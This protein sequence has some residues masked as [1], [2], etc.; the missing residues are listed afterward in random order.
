MTFQGMVMHRESWPIVMCPVCK[1]QPM[2]VMNIAAL[3]ADDRQVKLTYH[4]PQCRFETER[5]S[6]RPGTPAKAK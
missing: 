4:C 3:K 2:D 6:T 1:A 5:V